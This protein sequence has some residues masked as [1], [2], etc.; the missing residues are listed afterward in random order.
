MPLVDVWTLWNKGE[1]FQKFEHMATRISCL[2]PLEET[3]VSDCNKKGM[4]DILRRLKPGLYDPDSIKALDNVTRVLQGLTADRL[5]LQDLPDDKI[6]HYALHHPDLSSLSILF[7]GSGRSASISE[8]SM[9]FTSN[10]DTEPVNGYQRM[11]LDQTNDVTIIET[12]LQ[13]QFASNDQSNTPFPNESDSTAVDPQLTLWHDQF[14]T[15]TF[16]G[17]W[18][19]RS[20]DQFEHC[21][22]S[23]QNLSQEPAPPCDTQQTLEF[24]ASNPQFLP[25]E[26]HDD[27]HHAHIQDAFRKD[28]W[29]FGLPQNH[30]LLTF[31]CRP[32]GYIGVG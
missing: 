1:Q 6:E 16:S 13:D 17:G 28:P 11:E 23:D 27:L 24:E 3:V 19:E 22:L 5:H 20:D 10:E 8:P 7:V 29:L 18:C 32:R 15:P 9:G 2:W 4:S 25:P 30:P 21:L 26:A 12:P 31:S 14:E